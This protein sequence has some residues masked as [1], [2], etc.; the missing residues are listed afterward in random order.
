VRG[1]LTDGFDST[2]KSLRT[3][4]PGAR[5][6]NG[7][8][9]A[10]TELP[11]TLTAIEAPVRKAL[12][13]RFHTLLS[14]ARQRK[15]PRVLALGQRLRRF[16][17]HVATTAGAANGQRARRWVQN[18]KAGWYTVLADPR[19]P[20]TSTLLDQ[21]HHVIE[22]KLFAMKGFHPPK[23]NQQVFLRGLAYLYHLGPYQRRAQHAGQCGVRVEGG[24]L[25]TRD[26]F[27]NLQILTSGGVR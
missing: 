20:V 22:R 21:A 8:R 9:H 10:L 17:D 27:L 1:I 6:G 25:L 14:R 15:G 5:L 12:R 16:L 24:T 19:M 11:T 26:S 3:L 2:L 4:F 18:K 13:S 7:L 23:G